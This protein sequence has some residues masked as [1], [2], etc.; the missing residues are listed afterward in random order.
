MRVRPGTGT[1]RFPA[2]KSDG[3]VRQES[4]KQGEARDAQA[5]VG[6]AQERPLGQDGEEPQAGDRDRPVGGAQGRR[7]GPE[8]EERRLEEEA[9]LEETQELVAQE[10]GLA[11]PA[12]A[13]HF[14]QLE[15]R[16]HLELVVAAVLRRLVRAP[17]QE[18]RGMPEA[19]SLE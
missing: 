8:E 12:G 18:D 4:A 2:E 15:G 1:L 7:Q 9:R 14:L 17:A 13:E 10:E 6:H 3:T 5:Q 16:G 19:V 11:A